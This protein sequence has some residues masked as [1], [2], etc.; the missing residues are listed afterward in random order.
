MST[1]RIR[2]RLIVVDI[3]TG[4]DYRLGALP[5]SVNVPYGPDDSDEAF[6]KAV[7]AKV[8]KDK[9]RRKVICVAGNSNQTEVV[10]KA[11]ELMVRDLLYP[12]VCVL[13]N[14][15]D[16]FKTIPGVLFVPNA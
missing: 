10:A 6:C 5:G 14:G 16:I 8:P 4:P 1:N 11:A 13:H 2:S 12:R 3:R 7:C 15:I 9:V